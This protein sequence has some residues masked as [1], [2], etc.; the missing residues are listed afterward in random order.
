[1]TVA[2]PASL[3]VRATPTGGRFEVRVSPRAA[4]TALAGRRD[5]RLVV[6]VSAPPVDGAANDADVRII[7]ATLGLPPRQVALVTGLRGRTK[8]LDVHGLAASEI[9]RRL[10]EAVT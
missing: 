3:V 7:A 2:P 1:M 4:R 5:G 8:T 9:A 10:T 6:R